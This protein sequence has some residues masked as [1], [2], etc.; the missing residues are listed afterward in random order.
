MGYLDEEVDVSIDREGSYKGRRKF[1]RKQ[2]DI[3]AS[4]T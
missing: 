2:P 1:R 4:A 3:P